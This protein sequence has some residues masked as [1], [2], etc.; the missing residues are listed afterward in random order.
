MRA[1]ARTHK[2]THFKHRYTNAPSLFLSVSP[3]YTHTH[4]HTHIPSSLLAL[5]LSISPSHS[6][7]HTHRYRHPQL[8]VFFILSGRGPWSPRPPANINTVTCQPMGCWGQ[9]LLVFQA[10]RPVR[11]RSKQDA[12]TI[13]VPR[14]SYICTWWQ[15]TQQECKW[16]KKPTTKERIT[17]KSQKFAKKTN[18]VKINRNTNDDHWRLVTIA[19]MVHMNRCGCVQCT[20]AA[21]SWSKQKTNTTEQAA[22]TPPKANTIWHVYKLVTSGSQKHAHVHARAHTHTHTTCTHSNTYAHT[23][24]RT[25]VHT[26]THTHI[27]LY[28]YTEVFNLQSL[29]RQ[30]AWLETLI[31]GR[32]PWK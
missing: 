13:A 7:T 27:H 17:I 24:A 9:S 20:V 5:P 32:G 18:V 14:S 31:P 21:D 10:D 6:H 16:K 1:R 28:I 3:S 22:Q 25:R 29:V 12:Q 19:V 15:C 23:H 30:T 8:Q 4:T 2:H 26:H 11:W